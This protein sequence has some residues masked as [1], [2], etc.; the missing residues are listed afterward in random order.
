MLHEVW[1]LDPHIEDVC[2]RVG[3]L[4][5]ASMAPNLYQ[6]YDDV[7]TPENIQKAMEGVWDLSLEDRRD[8]GKVERELTKKKAGSDVK[9]TVGILY[10]QGFRDRLLS[11]A[12]NTVE[13]AYS[14]FGKVA[15]LGFSLGGGLSLKVA[16]KSR[17]LSAVVA[18]CGEPP[19]PE[20]VLRISAPILAIYASQDEIINQKVPAFVGTVLGTGKDLTLKVFPGTKH[21]FFNHTNGKIYDRE[22][23]AEAWELTGQF[24]RRTLG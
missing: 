18:F 9:E 24:L 3:K 20:D 19:D 22:A 7:L 5:F 23:T 8:K 12:M 17:Q 21:G 1:G 4:G 14:R 16:A 15:T 13:Q 2:K 6:G 10:D 11:T